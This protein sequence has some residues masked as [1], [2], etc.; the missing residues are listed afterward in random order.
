MYLSVVARPVE[1]EH[2]LL[3]FVTIVILF[4]VVSKFHDLFQVCELSIFFMQE[5]TAELLVNHVSFPTGNLTSE[6]KHFTYLV[7]SQH[8][9]TYTSEHTALCVLTNS[10]CLLSPGNVRWLVVCVSE[11]ELPG[12][13][14]G[15]VS[16]WR[17]A[18]TGINPL[19]PI[20]PPHWPNG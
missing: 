9:R 15:Q 5:I 10:C 12:W 19:S 13:P 17:G 6:Q 1:R 7:S 8:F 18:D 2:C 4:L 16:A 20:Q 14:S 11:V 3:A